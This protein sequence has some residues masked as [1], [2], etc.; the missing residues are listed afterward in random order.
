MEVTFV[1]I[2]F[3][4]APFGKTPE[5]FNTINMGIVFHKLFI[6][7]DAK[8]FVISDMHKAIIAAPFVT[9]Y[10]AFWIYFTKN[11]FL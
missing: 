4:E 9:S 7:I 10:N 6:V 8:M 1:A 11:Y 3:S 5:R 2:K